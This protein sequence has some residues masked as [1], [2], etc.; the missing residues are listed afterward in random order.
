V[1]ER[2]KRRAGWSTTRAAAVVAK[3]AGLRGWPPP[4]EDTEQSRGEGRLRRRAGRTS[5]ATRHTGNL[6][7]SEAQRA[8]FFQAKGNQDEQEING[9]ERVRGIC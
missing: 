3:N 9:G 2:A 7:R 8:P 1:A 5:R 6:S 4:Q